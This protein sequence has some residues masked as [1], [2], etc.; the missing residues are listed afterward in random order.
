[1]FIRLVRAELL[2]TR[3]IPILMLMAL[4]VAGVIL[5]GFSHF[6]SLSEADYNTMAAYDLQPNPWYFYYFGT[7]L[8]VYTL[9][10]PLALS[11][12][13]FVIKSVEDKADAWKRTL[14][15]PAPIYSIHLSKLAVIC[16]YA[17]LFVGVSLVGLMLSG[18]LLSKLRPEFNFHEYPTYHKFL[19]ILF[20]KFELAA[21]AIVTGGYA[22]MLFIKKTLV[23]LLLTV[24]LPLL[25]FLLLPPY[26]S[27]P[28][29]LF[30][31][32]M[33]RSRI[34]IRDGN[35]FTDLHLNLITTTDAICIGII[36]AA[37]IVVFY[38]STR[39]MV[40]YE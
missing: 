22:Y 1:M 2:K 29:Q 9:I 23:S 36:A 24:L 5:I 27:A 16:F 28:T 21:L 30:L 25:C 14:I 19:T 15:L 8:L 3:N 26:N 31:F 10:L 7:G 13:P 40:D 35:V 18:L 39:P 20:F 4:F 38:K 12:L 11:I 17:S 32:K 34:L 33:E 6:L 37:L